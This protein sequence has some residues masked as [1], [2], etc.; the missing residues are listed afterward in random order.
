MDSPMC[1]VADSPSWIPGPKLAKEITSWP[2]FQRR[3]FRTRTSVE[4][5]VDLVAMPMGATRR[6]YLEVANENFRGRIVGGYKLAPLG[7]SYS[8]L[9][10][11]Q[12]LVKSPKASIQRLTATWRLLHRLSHGSCWKY[13]R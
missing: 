13:R 3:M 9:P 6:A 12:W 1:H 7:H 4:P 2:Y 11:D 10:R 8:N 5:G